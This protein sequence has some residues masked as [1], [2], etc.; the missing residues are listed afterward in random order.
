[1]VCSDEPANCA[2]WPAAIIVIGNGPAFKET[3]GP[4]GLAAG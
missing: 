1:M 2:P 3:T 4:E